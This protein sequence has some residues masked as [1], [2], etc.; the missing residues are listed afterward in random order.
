MQGKDPRMMKSIVN[1]ILLDAFKAHEPWLQSQLEVSAVAARV[2]KFVDSLR[3]TEAELRLLA[4]D[5]KG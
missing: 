4:A 5:R 2:Y 3:L 1:Q